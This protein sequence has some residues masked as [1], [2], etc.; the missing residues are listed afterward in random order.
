V[1]FWETVG[2]EKKIIGHGPKSVYVTLLRE[3]YSR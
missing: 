3:I 2:T 1:T